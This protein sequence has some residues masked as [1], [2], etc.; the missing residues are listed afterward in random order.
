MPQL[1][2]QNAAELL[3]AFS[4]PTRLMIL[5][6][7]ASGP[8]CVTDIEELLSVKQAN[9]SQHLTVLRHA[10]LVDYAQD[11]LLRCYYVSRPHLV[12]DLLALMQRVE[13]P[14]KRTPQEI[15]ADKKRLAK[16][17][18]KPVEPCTSARK[19]RSNR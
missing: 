12:R 17:L 19:T 1:E 9:V 10:R 5:K 18:A 6:E 16:A 8:K 4:H 14:I 11:G 15:E 13:P 3:K 7:L 2:N